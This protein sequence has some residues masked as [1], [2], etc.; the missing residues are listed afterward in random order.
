M[1]LAMARVLDWLYP[2]IDKATVFIMAFLVLAVFGFEHELRHAVLAGFHEWIRVGPLTGI[3]SAAAIV[4]CLGAA[5]TFPFLRHDF[6]GLATVVLAVH[7]VALIAANIGYAWN[8][9]PGVERWASW[10]F[11]AYLFGWLLVIRYRSGVELI[12]ARDPQ[13]LEAL[14]AA[15]LSTA[16]FGAAL[17]LLD[18]HW[19]AAYTA[20]VAAASLI[21]LMARRLALGPLASRSIE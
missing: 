21:H 2:P 5:L 18:M 12:G 11:A 15:V 13:P 10:A 8:S 4:A 9:R 1:T 20:A 3:A 19:V 6:R 16:L 7:A 17:L 14:F